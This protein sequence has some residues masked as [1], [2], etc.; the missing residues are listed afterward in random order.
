MEL[1][2]DIVDKLIH[3]KGSPVRKPLI[4]SGARQIGKTWL[5]KYF[6]HNH[7]R[8]TAYFNFDNSE[9]LCRE[10]ENTKDPQRLIGILGLY[11]DNPI[12]PGETLI[13]FDEIQQS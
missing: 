5:M 12:L 13:I 7:F 2:R 3:W 11:T 4:I 6:G 1:R 9:E 10:F 8:H